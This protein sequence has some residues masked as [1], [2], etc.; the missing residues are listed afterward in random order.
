MSTRRTPQRRAGQRAGLTRDA[1]LAAARRIADREGSDGLTMRRL[2]AELGVM[3]NALYS[4]YPDKEALLDAMLD[5]LLGDVEVPDPA[6]GDWRDGLAALMDSS[7]RLLLAHPQ[8]ASMF[9]SRAAVGPNASRLGETA[10]RLLRRGGLEGE[11][12]VE[13][14]RVVLIY[15]L[16]FAAFQV[17]RRQADAADRSAR[18]REAF[19]SLPPEEFPE[20]RRVA[21]HLA[22]H[23]TDRSFHTGLRWLLDGMGSEGDR[24]G[25]GSRG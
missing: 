12:A 16:G 10:F 9:L 25:G 13:A 6:A 3:P 14:F 18:G 8:L 22:R 5:A 17:P 4:H 15:T 11:R 24:A 2:A 23:P 20:M 19:G 21:E 7:R 1:I